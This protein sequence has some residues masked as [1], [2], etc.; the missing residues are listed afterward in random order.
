MIS[1][2]RKKNSKQEKS[3]DTAKIPTELFRNSEQ[4]TDVLT[5]YVNKYKTKLWPEKFK[6]PVSIPVLEKQM[7]ENVQIIKQINKMNKAIHGK[8]KCQM[9]MCVM[10]TN[11]ELEKS[12]CTWQGWRSRRERK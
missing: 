10:L 3:T 11:D 4:A 6:R 2:Y 1:L 5:S 9:N 12:V 7:Q 8:K